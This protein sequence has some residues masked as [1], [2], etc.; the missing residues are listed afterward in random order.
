MVEMGIDVR[1]RRRL[2]CVRHK[3]GLTKCE[4]Y[5]RTRESGPVKGVNL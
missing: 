3:E 1:W 2:G 4:I 5:Q